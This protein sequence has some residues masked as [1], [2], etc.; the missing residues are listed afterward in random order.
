MPNGHLASVTLYSPNAGR[1]LS[2]HN[3]SGG[4]GE[5]LDAMA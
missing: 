1:G 5:G 2:R 3:S 4:A